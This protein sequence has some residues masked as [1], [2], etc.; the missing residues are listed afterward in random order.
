ML[1]ASLRVA[2]PVAAGS[3]EVWVYA[4]ALD[5]PADERRACAVLLSA[6]ERVRAAGFRFAV[7]RERF[8]VARGLLRRVLARHHDGAPECLPIVADVYG[9]PRLAAA[10]A[11]RF[12]VTHSGDRGLVAVTSGRELGIDLERGQRPIA[13]CE[14]VARWCCTAGERAALARIPAPDRVEAFRRAW[15]RKEAC[16][17]AS[18]LGL[19][20]PLDEVEVGVEP[21]A[22][23]AGYVAHVPRADDRPSAWTLVDLDVGAADVAALAVAR[24][25]AIAER[26]CRGGS[27]WPPPHPLPPLTGN[28]RLD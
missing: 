2:V 9:K 8:V 13:D 18:G 19:R 25:P 14:A 26:P 17:K 28:V 4:L 12:S 15:V 3:A 23:S 5:V 11:L 21:R 1:S 24:E 22:P 16:V 20:T 6:D 7:D 10:G 27:V